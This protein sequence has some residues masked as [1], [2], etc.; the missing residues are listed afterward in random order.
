MRRAKPATITLLSTTRAGRFIVQV[1]RARQNC[2]AHAPLTRG[3]VGHVYDLRAADTC[4][5]PPHAYLRRAIAQT[6]RD[7]RTRMGR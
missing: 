6:A 5:L 1:N 3:V 2:G 7:L 4:R